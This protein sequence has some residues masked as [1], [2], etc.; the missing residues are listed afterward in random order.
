M[1]LCKGIS[2]DVFKT[3]Y[4]EWFKKDFNHKKFSPFYCLWGLNLSMNKW[5]NAVLSKSRFGWIS[6]VFIINLEKQKVFFNLDKKIQLI[7]IRI[8]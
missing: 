4:E 7:M 8:M 2:Y 6:F 3:H 1:K 5:W